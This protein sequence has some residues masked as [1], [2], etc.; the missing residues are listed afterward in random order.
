MH[1]TVG[2]VSNR[3][4]SRRRRGLLGCAGVPARMFAARAAPAVGRGRCDARR[5]AAYSLPAATGGTARGRV[6]EIAMTEYEAATLATRYAALVIAAMLGS[7]QCLLIWI[8]LRFMRRSAELREQ[9]LKQQGEAD[10][11]RHK[12]AMEAFE[13]RHNAAMKA[14]ADRHEAAMKA[15]ADRHNA[16][17]K[18]DADRHAEAMRA[19]ERQERESDRRHAAAMAAHAETMA[20]LDAQRQAID[21]QAKGMET[22]IERTAPPAR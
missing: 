7:T 3:P 13:K 9:G 6:M 10:K 21:A 8:G 18:A 14:D 5:R 4:Q 19:F 15:Q 17:M 11:R 16:A 12:E 2:A 1:R 22:L 20:V